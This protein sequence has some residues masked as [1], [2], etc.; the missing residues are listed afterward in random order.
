M[1]WGLDVDKVVILKPALQGL[2][3]HITHTTSCRNVITI[4]HTVSAVFIAFWL[5][6]AS[7]EKGTT[8]YGIAKNV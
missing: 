7:F 4:R 1:F 2:T 8:L 3:P 6:L 5:I